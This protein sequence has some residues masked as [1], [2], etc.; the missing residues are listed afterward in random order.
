VCLW[1]EPHVHV[2]S[3]RFVC[4]PSLPYRGAEMRRAMRVIARLM[5][6]GARQRARGAGDGGVM[7]CGLMVGCGSRLHVDHRRALRVADNRVE[8]ALG[9]HKVVEDGEGGGGPVGVGRRLPLAA[10]RV[11]DP[12]VVGGLR[13][14]LQYGPKPRGVR[15]NDVGSAARQKGGRGHRAA[16]ARVRSRLHY[17]GMGREGVGEAG[18]LLAEMGRGAAAAVKAEEAEAFNRPR[19]ERHEQGE[20]AEHVGVGQ[21]ARPRRDGRAGG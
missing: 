19:H 7:G 4:V 17:E 12:Q 2:A 18:Q 16:L 13:E 14:D 10:G 3:G 15:A 11:A 8:G 9:A 5:G 21:S 6:C 1:C 20:H